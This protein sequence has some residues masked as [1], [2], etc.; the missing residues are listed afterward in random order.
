MAFALAARCSAPYAG[1]RC[2]RIGD[3]A[4]TRLAALT[5]DQRGASL[6]FA[7]DVAVVVQSLVL[8]D[9]DLL[10]TT[11]GWANQSIVI[12]TIGGNRGS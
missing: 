8:A 5:L 11:A 2:S 7:P 12:V 3:R 9:C 4:P 1:G 10:F 6:P